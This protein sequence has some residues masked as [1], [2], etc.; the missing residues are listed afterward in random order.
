MDLWQKSKSIPLRVL[1][2]G[3]DPP[4]ALAATLLHF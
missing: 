4:A 2:G 1:S 3:Q